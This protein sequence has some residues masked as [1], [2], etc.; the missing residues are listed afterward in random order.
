MKVSANESPE[1]L[2]KGKEITHYNYN[3]KQVT[4]EEPDGTSHISYEYEYVEIR[5]KITRGKIIQA[6]E[7]TKLDIEE[8]FDP[9]EIESTYNAAKDA[10]NLSEIAKLTYEQLDTYI[11]N[12]VTNLA[13]AKTYLKKLS[14]VML[15]IVRRN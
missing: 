10:I 9:S 8:D 3:I 1:R 5:G 13:G 11:D 2:V 12:N 14:K 6:L 15:A 4:V 7:D